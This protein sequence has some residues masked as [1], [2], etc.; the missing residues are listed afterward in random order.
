MKTTFSKRLA[1]GLAVAAMGAIAQPLSAQ[2]LPPAETQLPAAVEPNAYLAEQQTPSSSVSTSAESLAPQLPTVA[3]PELAA[4]APE[5]A[6]AQSD[7]ELG[8]AT[9]SGRSYIGVGG[10]IGLS[11]GTALG[12]GSF[13]I[14]SK[15][16][17]TDTLSLRPSVLL[18][19]DATFLIPITYDFTV[20]TSDDPFENTRFAPY[21]GGGALISTG[22]NSNVGFLLTG[23]I[24]IPLSREF[25]ATAAVN[26]GF[27]E[28]RTPVGIMLGVGYTFAGF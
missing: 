2:T 18:G 20:R 21:L 16:G 24:D 12:D 17:L 1:L 11:D 4:Q 26:V 9:R 5:N 7:I 25:T 22:N 27:T 10:N 6:I 3:I 8:R 28:N 19:N 15:I 14:I 13:A 23:G